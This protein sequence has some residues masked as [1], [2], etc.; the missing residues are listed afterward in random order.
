MC[1]NVRT[2]IYWSLLI[3]YFDFFFLNNYLFN[4]NILTFYNQFK[5][6]DVDKSFF[7]DVE[8]QKMQA[9]SYAIMSKSTIFPL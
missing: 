5:C 1:V 2:N 7:N 8:S 3:N 6:K 4:L 9:S